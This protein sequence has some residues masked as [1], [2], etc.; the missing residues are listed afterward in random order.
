MEGKQRETMTFGKKQKIRRRGKGF[1]G[2]CLIPVFLMALLTGCR[3]AAKQEAR[4]TLFL[5][6]TVVTQEWYGEKAEETCDEIETALRELEQKVSLYLEDSEVS[7][8]NAAAG[9]EYV[10]VSEEI[11][12][13]IKREKALSEESGGIFDITIA[14]LVLLW[15]ITGE[16]PHV[17]EQEEIDEALTKVDCTKILLDEETHSVMLEDEGMMLD[18]GGSAKGLAAEKM[19][20]IAEDNGVSGYLSIGGN[21]L[22]VGEKPDGSDFVIGIRDPNGDANDYFATVTM[23]GYTM[24]TSSAVE[25]FFEEDGVTYHH[26][27][28]PFTGYPAATDLLSVTVISEDG[29]LADTLSTT[30]FL[31]GSTCL[32]QYINREDCMVAAMTDTGNVVVS[33]GLKSMLTLN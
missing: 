28:N 18:L 8:I 1:F 12:D 17:P 14:P 16:D 11:F 6:D 13:M 2:I 25:R 26:I 29:L 22:V 4:E 31:K 33:E 7:A 23:E 24:A 5:M 20:K 9:K 32:E 27:L 19:R 21:M 30:I 3:P 15:D 10:P